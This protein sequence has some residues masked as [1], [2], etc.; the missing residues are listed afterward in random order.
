VPDARQRAKTSM[1]WFL[2]D[3]FQS[4]FNNVKE[5]TV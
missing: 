1:A 3:L 2:L 4:R 5:L